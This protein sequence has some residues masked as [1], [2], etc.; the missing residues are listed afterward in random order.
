MHLKPEKWRKLEKTPAR[1]KVIDKFVSSVQRSA[2]RSARPCKGNPLTQIAYE[3]VELSVLC[4][5]R[6]VDKTRCVSILRMLHGRYHFR[7]QL[8]KYEGL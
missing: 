4:S 5:R 7:L 1:T 6:E 2:N 3:S 8:R